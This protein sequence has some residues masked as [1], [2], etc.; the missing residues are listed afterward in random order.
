M[1]LSV[2]NFFLL[3]SL[4]GG[5]GRVYL[6]GG[7]RC[8]EGI[9]DGRFD[10]VF[11]VLNFFDFTFYLFIAA[12]GGSAVVLDAEIDAFAEAGGVVGFAVR[13]GG[14][15]VVIQGGTCR[16][17]GL[18]VARGIADGGL[19]SGCFC[20]V[21]FYFFLEL[22]EVGGDGRIEFELAS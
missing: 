12:D 4:G 20:L 14:A 22:G 19:E 15:V 9:A 13:G 5:Y 1:G 21:I 10:A 3:R 7:L 11:V 16:S 17:G 2:R 6:T 8:V 18:R